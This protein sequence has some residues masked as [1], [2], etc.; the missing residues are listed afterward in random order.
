MIAD[1]IQSAQQRH[2]S[3]YDK[4]TR[5]PEYREGRQG[6]LR[7]GSPSTEKDNKTDNSPSSDSQPQLQV[8][9]TASIPQPS[10]SATG[11]GQS[12][13]YDSEEGTDFENQSQSRED[14]IYFVERI[15][16]CKTINNVK[17]YK[18]KWSGHK[19]ATWEPSHVPAH[20]IREFHLEKTNCGR[21][22]RLKVTPKNRV[23]RL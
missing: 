21:K 6:L 13:H 15:L 3:Q 1:N 5:Q 17:H 9:D 10:T 8:P 22:R 16:A 20:L 19:N 23:T 12:L 4:K 11:S 7:Q 18:I 2:K 14:E